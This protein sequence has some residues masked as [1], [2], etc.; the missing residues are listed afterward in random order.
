[1]AALAATPSLG[2]LL[3]CVLVVLIKVGLLIYLP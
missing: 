3:L 1:M 2:A